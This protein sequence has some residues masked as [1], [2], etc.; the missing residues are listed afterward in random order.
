MKYMILSE[1]EKILY[2]YGSENI[3]EALETDTGKVVR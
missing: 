1:D 3:I 2:G